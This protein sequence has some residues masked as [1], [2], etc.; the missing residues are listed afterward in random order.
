VEPVLGYDYRPFMN[1]W[2]F[3]TTRQ[4]TD[5][6]I[7]TAKEVLTRRVADG[8]WGLAENAPNGRHLRKGDE[9]V[10]YLGSPDMAFAASAALASDFFTLSHEQKQKYWH[11]KVFEAECGVL[12]DNAQLWDTC[13]FRVN[14]K[15]AELPPVRAWLVAAKMPESA[16]PRPFGNL[17]FPAGH[18]ERGGDL[19]SA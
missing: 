4:Q 13:S 15:H 17:P 11:G 2:L 6:R 18:P 16:A 5:G 1:Y 10:F 3:I 19:L 9:A 14:L 7:V 12:L 8:F